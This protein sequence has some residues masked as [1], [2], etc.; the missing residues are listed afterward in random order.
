MVEPVDH[1]LK[2]TFDPKIAPCI[3][4][5]GGGI[6]DFTSPRTNSAIKTVKPIDPTTPSYLTP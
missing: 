6:A 4:Q 5:P 2:V 3:A 1:F